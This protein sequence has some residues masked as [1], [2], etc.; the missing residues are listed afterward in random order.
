MAAS[1]AV[2]A[3]PSIPAASA[4]RPISSSG[5]APRPH[6]R[7]LVPAMSAGCS[8]SMS[9]A[10]P[11]PSR[12]SNWSR[13]HLSPARRP[14]S[15][16]SS[17][18]TSARDVGVHGKARILRR[19]HPLPQAHLQAADDSIPGARR[20]AATHSCG[21]QRTLPSPPGSLARVRG[22]AGITATSTSNTDSS[23]SP[24]VR[25]SRP[26]PDPSRY[27][28]LCGLLPGQLPPHGGSRRRHDSTT[29]TRADLPGQERSISPY[30]RRVYV[31][32]QL[33]V[34]G[35]RCLS[36][37]TQIAP[38]CTRFVFPSAGFRL[39][40]PSHP[41]SRRRSCLRLGVSSTS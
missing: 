3:P 13:T 36:R 37:L 41:A 33:I 11:G 7:V 18:P 25:P 40:P 22:M 2:A 21:A 8:S 29:S 31:T 27:Y 14:W 19:E 34:T 15:R 17:R 4:A 20:P 6:P 35:F 23:V 38:P 12:A 5:W 26:R 10:L 24:D 32:T 28:D 39:G 30:A 9:S 16:T 1:S